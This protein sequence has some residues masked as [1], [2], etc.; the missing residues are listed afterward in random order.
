METLNL[1][2]RESVLRPVHGPAFWRRQ[3]VPQV[4]RAQITFD[5]IFGIVGP[6]LCF[7]FDPIVFR[8]GLGD[9]PLLVDYKV[10]VYLFSGL[11]IMM[12]SFWLLARAGFQFWNDL[13]GTGLYLGGVF[14]LIVGVVLLPFSLMGLMLGVGI[15]GFTPFLTGIVYLR[16]GLRALRSPRTDSSI[17]TVAVTCLLGSVVVI[18]AP[19][20]SGFVI[21]QA[22]DSSVEEIVNGDARQASAAAHRIWPLRYFVGDVSNK[23]VTAYE[24]AA[25]PAR[26]ELLKNCYQEITGED[27]ELRIRVMRD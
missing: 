2:E 12:L 7:A 3:F 4:T 25:D 6:M 22:V 5:I 20:L 21:H 1:I 9:R 23:I 19:L 15:F 18:G 11:E 17:F 16:N 14:C 8:G 26:K 10:Y 13:V 27:I 24:Q